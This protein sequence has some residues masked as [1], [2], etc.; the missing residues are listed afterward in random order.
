[1][2]PRQSFLLFEGIYIFSPGVVSVDEWGV[3]VVVNVSPK[4]K[5]L[6][7]FFL[8]VSNDCESLLYLTSVLPL[9]LML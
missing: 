3:V 6:Q 8:G 1:M 5:E 2:L 9:W 7:I 4:E